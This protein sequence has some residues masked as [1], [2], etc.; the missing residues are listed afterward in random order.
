MS[1]YSVSDSSAIQYEM[2]TEDNGWIL[3][4]RV[5]SKTSVKDQITVI[6]W[7]REYQNDLKRLHPHWLT[8]FRETERGYMLVIQKAENV[9]ELLN[10]VDLMSE[11]DRVR[12]YW[13]KSLEYAQ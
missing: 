13:S 12:D 1:A 6:D 9:H 10:A 3:S 4:V 5:P 8:A 7:L 11:G 2:K